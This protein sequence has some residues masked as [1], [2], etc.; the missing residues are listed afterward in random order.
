MKTKNLQASDIGIGDQLP[1]LQVPITAQKIISA[2]AA[3]RDWQPIHHDHDIA[4]KS[5]LRGI[6]LNAP[7]QTGWISRYVTD[8]AGSQA[9]IK[10]LSFK[11]KD[12][13]CPGDALTI[14]GEIIGKDAVDNGLTRITA[15]VTLAVGEIIKTIADVRFEL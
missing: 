6:I 7:S 4:I 10:R 1:V 2:A 8:W 5:G 3:T 13:I 12:S 14:S 11:M 15:T 9:Q